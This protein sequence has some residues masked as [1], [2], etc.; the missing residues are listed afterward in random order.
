MDPLSCPRCGAEMHDRIVGQASVSQCPDGHGV[1]LSRAE[2][3]TLIES[4]TDWHRG[5]SQ[6]TAPMPKIT[7]DMTAPPAATKRTRAWIETLFD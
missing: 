4:E 2:L 5:T 3:G 6:H 7:A 1:F